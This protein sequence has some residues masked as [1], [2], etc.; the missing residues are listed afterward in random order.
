MSYEKRR[1]TRGGQLSRLELVVVLAAGEGKRMK[2]ALPKVLHQVAG[3]SLLEHVVRAASE[4]ESNEVRVVVGAG[5][6]EVIAELA[7]IAPKAASIHQEKRSGTGAAV[8]LALSDGPTNG[9]V[10]ICAGDTPLLRSATLLSLLQAHRSGD[11]AATVLTTEHPDPTGYGRI[12]RDKTGAFAAIVEER[13][14]TDEQREIVEVNAGVYVFDIA[15]LRRALAALKPHNAQQEEYLTDVLEILRNDGAAITTHSVADF[16]EVLGVNDRA[17]LA[18]VALVY[19]GLINEA[20]AQSGVTIV[21][22]MNTWIDVSAQIDVDVRIEPGS[23][24]KGA[25]RIGAGAIIGP[26]T[27]LVDCE[28]G[29]GATIIESNC[30]GASIGAGASVGPYSYLRVG[31]VL[32][33]G[34]RVGAFVEVK[35]S[36]IG[37]ASKVPHLS[38]VGDAVIGSGSNI[39]AG[40]IFANYDGLA[41]HETRIGDEVRIG[42][43]T[44]LVAPVTVGDGAYTA[45]GSAITEDVPPG[46]LGVGRGRQVNILGWV[47]KRRKGSRSDA[48]ASKSEEPKKGAK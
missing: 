40:T 22:S 23:F 39:G 20:L 31:A 25:T 48:A 42:S 11:F 13:D 29:A 33:E 41:K 8:R 43:D 32:G 27:T 2:S 45:A 19:Q 38:Y 28:V 5:K 36:T 37:P 24:I 10:L 9:T 34:A 14:A 7:K 21:D 12:I 44:V 3:R 15:S 16:T 4:I 18:N 46:A 26:R 47:R 17:Q 35:N 30:V 1:A 6:E